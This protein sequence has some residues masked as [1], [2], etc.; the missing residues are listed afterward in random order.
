MPG[1]MTPRMP[2]STCILTR[3]FDENKYNGAAIMPMKKTPMTLTLAQPAV[4]A[5][6]PHTSHA[7]GCEAAGELGKHIDINRMSSSDSR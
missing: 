4:I 7:A 1:E 3:R 5:T 6:R 2:S